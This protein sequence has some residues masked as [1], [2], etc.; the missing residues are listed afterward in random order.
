M[1]RKSL[2]IVF[3]FLV[4]C[5]EKAEITSPER[6]DI[7]ESIYASGV[8]RSHNQYDLFTKVSGQVAELL[9]EVGDTVVIGQPILRI[10]SELQRLNN[11][12]AQLT[13]RFFS[14]SNNRDELERLENAIDLAKIKQEYDSTQ[15]QRQKKLFDKG[16]GAKIDLETSRLAYENSVLAYKSAKNQYNQFKR[17]LRYNSNQA[18]NNY[19]I[20]SLSENDFTVFSKVN[21]IVY[22][23]NC[24][25]GELVTPQRSL[26]VVGDN[27]HFVLEMLI[28]ESDILKIHHGQSVI[29]RL[30]SYGDQVFE[31]SVSKIFPFMDAQ[32]KSFKLE[33]Q[34]IEPP[35]RLYPNMNFEA[36]IVIATKENALLIPREFTINDSLVVLSSGDTVQ[37]ETGLKDYRKIEVIS[38]LKEADKIQKPLE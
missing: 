2:L 29:V 18:S 37:I 35:E 7:T 31:A 27:S 9:V 17:Q 5:S 8:I 3:A 36:N 19:R 6:E 16:A 24:E 13:S 32:S 26:G 12:N 14:E 28:D 20:S 1:K 33:A 10:E 34:F 11:E 30:D 23:L 38:G 22:D 4:A 15:Y 21:G 25:V